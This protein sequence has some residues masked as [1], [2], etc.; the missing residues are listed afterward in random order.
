MVVLSSLIQKKK[1]KS[2]LT[3]ERP[4]SGTKSQHNTVTGITHFG[5]YPVF[6]LGS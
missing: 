5:S 4:K 3:D 6:S 2:C 1:K